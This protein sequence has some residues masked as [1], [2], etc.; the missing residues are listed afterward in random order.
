M[1]SG[2]ERR[3]LDAIEKYMLD[4]DPDLCRALRMGESIAMRRWKLA[5]CLGGVSLGAVLV[6]TGVLMLSLGLVIFGSAVGSMGVLAFVRVRSERS[7]TR[8]RDHRDPGG[9]I[10]PTWW[11][12]A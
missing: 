2:P 1:L 9:D 10:S 11:S 5:A 12:A 3:A 4:E 8:P 7:G 6:A